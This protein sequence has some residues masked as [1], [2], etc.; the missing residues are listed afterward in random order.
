MNTSAD[1]KSGQFTFA[2]EGSTNSASPYFIGKLSHPSA[3][4]GV[5]IGAGYDM[6][7]RTESQVKNDLVLA[8]LASETAAKLAKGAGMKGG[9]ADQ[10]VAANKADLIV[11]DLAVLKRLF[12]QVY[13]GYV[14]TAHDNFNYH[15]ATFRHSMPHYGK[16]FKDATFFSWEHLY[17]AIRVIAIDF[18]YQGFGKR[19]AG[20]GRPMHFCMANDFDWLI[21]YITTTPGLN[22]YESGRGRAAYLRGKKDFETRSYSACSVI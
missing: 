2:A 4:S 21:D 15:A 20:Y 8:G 11:K 1:E 16:K 14:S 5:T 22:R 10:F 17:P 13:P 3:D 18:T 19:Q 6:G 7:G 12:D 9:Q